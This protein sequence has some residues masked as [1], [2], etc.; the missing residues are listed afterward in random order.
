M[1]VVR[2]D[3]HRITIAAVLAVAG[4]LAASA[5]ASAHCDTLNGPVVAAARVALATGDVTPVL[6]WVK[7]ADEPE[8]RAAFRKAAAH[9]GSDRFFFETAVRLHRS[10]EGEPYTGLKDEPPAPAIERADRA[11]RTG[12][13]APL[14][15]LLG[16]RADAQLRERFVRARAL[17]QDAE[18]SVDAGRRFVS[19]YVEFIRYVEELEGEAS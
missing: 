4:V 11:L 14:V 2:N 6:K 9:E 1:G 8:V 5:P 18:S 7:P 10:S 16:G 19:A 12:D 17:Q 15:T 13:L 3:M